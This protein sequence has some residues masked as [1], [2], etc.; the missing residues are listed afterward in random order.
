VAGAVPELHANRVSIV[1]ADGTLLARAGDDGKEDLGGGIEEM[2]TGYETRLGRT[3]EEMLERSLGP[4]KVRVEVHA[5]LDFDRVTTSSETYD[6]DGQVIRS[7]QSVKENADN[8][9]SGSEPVSVSTNLP[10]ATTAKPTAT[11]GG[12]RSKSGRSEETTNYE[13]SKTVKNQ[14][15]EG[16]VVRRLSVAVL[17]DG[18]YATA[19]DGTRNYQPRPQEELQQITTLVRSAIGYDQKRGDTVEVVNLRFAGSD[20]PAEEIAATYMGMNK[21]DFFRIGEAGVLMVVALLVILLVVR[22]VMNRVFETMT[23]AAVAVG[24]DGQ[25]LLT[26]QDG[27][28]G[29]LPAPPGMAAGGGAVAVAGAPGGD[30]ISEIEQMIDIGQVEGR[31]RASSLK[32]IGEIVEKHPEEA[33]AIVRSWM[34]Q[35]G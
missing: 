16:G 26:H 23:P 10:D 31:V 12:Q 17:L 18:S 7:T 5:D 32:K 27:T 9:E 22:P 20:E 28:A 35:E 2:R 30:P 11:G 21:T 33:L 1:D 34:Y 24:P 13:I 6:P 25:R 14:V 29:A 4:G 15:R 3:V 8:G 19:A